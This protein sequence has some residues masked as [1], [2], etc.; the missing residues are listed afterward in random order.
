MNAGVLRFFHPVLPSGLLR[1]SPRR[2]LV[3]GHPVALFRGLRGAPAAVDDQCPHRRASLS[4]GSVNCAGRIVCGYHGWH[5]GADGH[6]ASPSCPEL[7]RCDTRHWQVLDR[8]GFLWLAAPETPLNSFPLDPPHGFSFAGSFSTR[9]AAPIELALDNISEDEH[10]AFVHST[11]GW[12]PADAAK[13]TVHCDAS[14][15]RTEVRY[16]G[17]QRHSWI[18]PLGGVRAGDLFHNHWVTT[19]DPVKTVYTFGWRNPVTG[20]DRPILTRAVVFLVPVDPATTDVQMF[21]FVRIAPSLQA[22][23]APLFRWLAV[24]VAAMELRRD[25]AFVKH[26][27]LAPVSLDGMRLTRH[28]KALIRNRELLRR[29]YWNGASL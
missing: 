17:P 4:A 6:G 16:L 3:G 8:F 5:F 7:R 18:A 10:F 9:F 27:A 1:R 19:F 22:L 28:D 29:I 2:V 23:V 13:A 26:V 24:R 21:V 15:D 25:A 20:A 12:S 14:N 11:F